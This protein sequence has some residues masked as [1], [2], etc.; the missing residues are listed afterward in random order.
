MAFDI[1]NFNNISSGA[2]GTLRLWS[3]T[4]TDTTATV[5]A[6]AYFLSVTNALTAGD[7]I[8][9]KASDGSGWLEVLTA[10]A[11]TVTVSANGA[12]RASVAM[13]AAEWLGMYATPKLLIA[14]PGANK[15]IRVDAVVYEVD[16]GTTQFAAGGVFAPQYRNTANGAGTLCTGTIA[17]AVAT[18]WAA[19]NIATEVA[20]EVAATAAN[21]VNQGIYMS[22]QTAAFTTG[23]SLVTVHLDYRIVSLDL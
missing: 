8:Y 14:A 7:M 12:Q 19:D 16:Y 6:A 9:Y 23:D 3:Y 20:V 13:T 10:T 11:T 2:A 1:D 5:L 22:N 21:T 4:T 15:L 18:G 17:A